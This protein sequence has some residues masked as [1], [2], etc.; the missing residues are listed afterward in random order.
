MLLPV[1]FF[2]QQQGP[3]P[4]LAHLP[5][6]WWKARFGTSLNTCSCVVRCPRTFGLRD[7]LRIAQDAGTACC[8]H[9]TDATSS[10]FKPC[11]IKAILDGLM[12]MN[13]AIRERTPG[14]GNIN[15]PCLT[16]NPGVCSS[17]SIYFFTV[18]VSC[19]SH[20]AYEGRRC[21]SLLLLSSAASMPSAVFSVCSVAPVSL[22]A[23]TCMLLV[24]GHHFDG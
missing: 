1:I 11:L 2:T 16:S 21:G 13:G 24:Q 4:C 23:S 3:P 5:Q 20:H 7:W 6:V 15:L 17:L 9:H 12:V 10:A 18:N 14:P 19:W 22:A 8:S